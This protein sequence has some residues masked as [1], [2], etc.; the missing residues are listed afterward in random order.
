MLKLFYTIF[1][2]SLHIQMSKNGKFSWAFK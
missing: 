1:V 2:K